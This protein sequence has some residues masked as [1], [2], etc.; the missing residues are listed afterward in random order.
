MSHRNVSDYAASAIGTSLVIASFA[1]AFLFPNLGGILAFSLNSGLCGLALLSSE[2]ALER[3]PREWERITLALWLA[4]SPWLLGFHGAASTSGQA[5]SALP[6]SSY[7]PP[8][9]FPIRKKLREQKSWY[10]NRGSGKGN[11]LIN[12]S[13]EHD[14]IEDQLEELGSRL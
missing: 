9:R 11:L 12:R 14:S 7:Q 4:I 10:R 5:L 3:Y 8:G 2:N 13:Q 6:S 1:P